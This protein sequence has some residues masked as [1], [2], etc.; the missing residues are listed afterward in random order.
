MQPFKFQPAL[1]FCRSHQVF[2]FSTRHLIFLLI[3]VNSTTSRCQ[4]LFCHRNFS[5]LQILPKLF[6]CNSRAAE[7]DHQLHCVSVC[8]SAHLAAMTIICLHETNVLCT[9]SHTPN[10]SM[11]KTDNC[12]HNAQYNHC[13]EFRCNNMNITASSNATKMSKRQTIY[14]TLQ[15]YIHS[16]FHIIKETDNF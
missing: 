15:K 16:L 1:V 14:Y 6:R 9:T 11:L 3:L 12:E 8:P 4:Q 5:S 7:S 10:M 13:N 2:S